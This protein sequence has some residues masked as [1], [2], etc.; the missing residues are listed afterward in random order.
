MHAQASRAQIAP[1]AQIFDLQRCKAPH[2]HK[3]PAR[4]EYNRSVLGS[5]PRWSTM[6]NENRTS[7]EDWFSFCFLWD[8]SPTLLSGIFIYSKHLRLTRD[9]HLVTPKCWLLCYLIK[10]LTF[11]QGFVKIRIEQQRFSYSR[12]GWRVVIL[13]PKLQRIRYASLQKSFL[14]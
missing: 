12:K 2:F 9:N 7:K 4:K 13:S 11:V 8:L 6:L 14:P 10:F 5:S 1:R 3:M